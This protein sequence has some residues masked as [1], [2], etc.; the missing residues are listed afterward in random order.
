V[1]GLPA[2]VTFT[3]TES[4][5]GQYL[6]YSWNYEAFA[7]IRSGETPTPLTT[8]TSNALRVRVT[9]PD[10]T[11]ITIYQVTFDKT[12]AE[13][14]SSS[15]LLPEGGSLNFTVTGGKI[16]ITSSSD[17]IGDVTIPSQIGGYPVTSLANELFSGNAKI[18]SATI[19]DSVTTV[20]TWTFWSC[21]SM[22][23]VKLPAGLTAIT[24]NML[25]NCFVLSSVTIPSTVTSIGSHS[26][27]NC[28]ALQTINIYR[29]VPPTLN[30]GAFVSNPG[31]QIIYVPQ[32]ALN[33]Y[34]N[35]VVWKD[36]NVTDKEGSW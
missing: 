35:A 19:P 14:S 2:A 8:A 6:E 18:T 9:A 3:A 32:G 1:T 28:W 21:S 29:A 23:T 5:A 31:T 27:N 30:S 11:S 15:V 22:T 13:G 16:N 36:L 17:A 33:A 7:P 26:F 12:I 10:R 25:D 4:V 24:D 34:Q 20:G